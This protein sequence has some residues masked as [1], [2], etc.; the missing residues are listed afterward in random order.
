MGHQRVP[1]ESADEF[2]LVV[3]KTEDSQKAHKNYFR[4][5]PLMP[6]L[7]D[8]MEKRTCSWM[9]YALVCCTDEIYECTKRRCTIEQY[10]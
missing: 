1:V 3:Y 8:V 7:V 4:A 6:M 10:E 9:Q 5:F 2:F